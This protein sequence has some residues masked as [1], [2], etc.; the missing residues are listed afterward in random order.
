MGVG[1]EQIYRQRDFAPSERVRIVGID[2][3]KRSV[4][5]DIEFLNGDKAGTVENIP[6]GRL[7]G[8]WANVRDFDEHMALWERFCEQAMDEHEDA[9]VEQVF[10]LLI[11]DSVAD[12]SWERR[13]GS[14]DVDVDHGACG[15]AG[16][17]G[18]VLR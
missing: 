2:E 15:M 8:P 11:P 12:L 1:D 6:A 5:Y 17:P 4:R 3:R 14:T 13:I 7:R 9:A 16:S 10:L 18:M